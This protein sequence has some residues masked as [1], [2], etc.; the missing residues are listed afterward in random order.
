MLPSSTS[1]SLYREIAVESSLSLVSLERERESRTTSSSQKQLLL[2][3]L[4]TSTVVRR[5]D[6]RARHLRNHPG[7]PAFRISVEPLLVLLLTQIWN[8]YKAHVTEYTGSPQSSANR[9]PQK[10]APLVEILAKSPPPCIINIDSI[11]AENGTKGEK[12]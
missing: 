12:N 4:G 9:I 7:T 2:Y 6:G 1:P 5:T 8:T 11:L 3:L 10:R